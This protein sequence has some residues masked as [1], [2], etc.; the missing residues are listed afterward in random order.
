MIIHVDCTI[1][2]KEVDAAIKS[3]QHK[4]TIKS[5]FIGFFEIQALL[6]LLSEI[7]DELSAIKIKESAS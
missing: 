2:L 7:K 3:L 5:T 4:I 6:N 1:D